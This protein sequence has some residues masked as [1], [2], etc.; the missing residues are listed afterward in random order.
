MVERL[1][2]SFMSLRGGRNQLFVGNNNTD[3][4]F[5]KVNDC[6][7]AYAG[8][9]AIKVMTVVSSA[10]PYNLTLAARLKPFESRC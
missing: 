1:T 5:I 8:G 4:G 3:Q 10:S 9:A 6:T 2:F 7:F